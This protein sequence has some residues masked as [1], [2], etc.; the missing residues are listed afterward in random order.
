MI[1]SSVMEHA[2]CPLTTQHRTYDRYQAQRVSLPYRCTQTHYRQYTCGVDRDRF[3]ER[4]D[5]QRAS[6]DGQ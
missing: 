6:P 3:R 4:L 5:H 1:Q 2:D